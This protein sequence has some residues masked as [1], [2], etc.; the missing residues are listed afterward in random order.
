VG[1]TKEAVKPD[2]IFS[3][4]QRKDAMYIQRAFKDRRDY[5]RK[6][7]TK[8]EDATFDD[9]LE[10]YVTNDADHPGKTLA[11]FVNFA[12][13]LTAIYQGQVMQDIWALYEMDGKKEGYFVDF[14]ATNG[15]TLSNSYIL[16]RFFDWDGIVA[17][18]N[19][20]YHERLQQVRKCNVST[21]CVHSRTGK[22]FTFICAVRP[23]FSR[24]GVA[25]EG[26]TF[27][28]EQIEQSIKVPTISLNDLLDEHNAPEVVD[29]ISIDTEGS[30]L[31]ILSTFDFEKR[32]VNMFAVEHNFEDR[33]QPIFDMMTKAGY[34]RRFPEM[35]RFDDWYIHK[36][37]L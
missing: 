24:L 3:D 19:P 9:G 11:G 18:P 21:K 33:R 17:E 26:M 29:F 28:D 27:E 20:T 1:N 34:I 12:L 5:I 14:G 7:R 36:S 2:P 13:P 6:S 8:L 15:T 35:S 30:E 37:M 4:I 22:S 10:D 25:S 31:D 32:R 23:M 16:E